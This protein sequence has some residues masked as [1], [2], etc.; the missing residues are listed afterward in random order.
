MKMT[1]RLF[2]A[3]ILIS[4]VGLAFVGCEDPASSPPALT[5]TVSI[6]GYAR[7]GEMLSP[8]ISRLGGSGIISFQ[9]MRNG[10][11]VIGSGITYSVLTADAGSTIAVIVTRSD[12]SGSITSSSFGPI[13]TPVT[14]NG[15]TANGSAMQSTTELTL[16]FS[17]AIND[18]TADDITLS[19]VSGVLKGTLSESG[20]TYTLPI[21]GFTS[22]GTL[23][24]AAEK[25]GFTISG[26]P[27]TAT[28]YYATSVTFVGVTAN[29]SATQTTT[30]LTFAFSQAIDG[31]TADDITL[32]GIS[33]VQKGTLIGSGSTYTLPI[34]GLTSGGTLNLAVEKSGFSINGSP[35]TVTIYYYSLG[36]EMVRISSGT[37]TMGSSDGEDWNAIPPH[38][39]TLSKGFSMGKYE[40]TQGQYQEVTG[41]NPSSFSGSPASGET[42]TRRPVEG[43]TWYDA[44]EFCNKLSQQ[45]GLAPAYTITDRSPSSGYP[46]TSATVTANWDANGYRIPTEAEWEYACRAG[47]TTTWSFGSTESHAADYAWYESNSSNMTHEVGRKLPNAWG[48]YDMHG[49]VWEWCWDWYGE[50]SSGAQTDP[51]GAVSGTFRVP[52]GGSWFNSAHNLHS[53]GRSYFIPDFGN[54][55]FGFRLVRL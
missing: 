10:S 12:N 34:S 31:L 55:R 9:W 29:G 53:A 17:Q 37:F 23:N 11:T 14:F 22:G 33:G 38:Q 16:A 20:S 26:S 30:E 43:V 6:M 41:Q 52:R 24:V 50:Y 35:K 4:L 2:G 21:S 42:Q 27:K 36:V 5:G 8:D 13:D 7:V 49:N 25:A 45:E 54:Y 39:V 3:I 18:L 32:S 40:V 1:V 51:H 19:G 28:I 46:I 48:L 15:A 44:V 47:T